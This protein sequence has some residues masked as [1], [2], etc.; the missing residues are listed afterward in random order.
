M[1]WKK[2]RKRSSRVKAF[3]LLGGLSALFSCAGKSSFSYAPDPVESTLGEKSLKLFVATDLHYLAP[4]LT[5]YGTAFNETID[6]SDAK[7]VRYGATILDA[8]LAE[9]EAAKPDALL[10]SGDLT[11]NGEERSHQ[12]L[13]AK[14][15][16]LRE[17]GIAILVIPGNHD[18]ENPYSYAYSD[19][20]VT[21]V[22]SVDEAGFLSLYQDVCFHHVLSFDPDSLSYV[23]PLRKDLWLLSLSGDGDQTKAGR[24]PESTLSWAK[25]ELEKARKQGIKV[26]GMTHESVLPQIP[27]FEE[28]SLMNAFE[29]RDLYE[30]EGVIANLSGHLHLQHYAQGEGFPD[31][32]TSSMLVSP[33]HYAEIA[34][35]PS[36]FAYTTHSIDVASY[37][38]KE[39][40]S[41]P[42]LLAFPA[43]AKDFFRSSNEKRVRGRLEG[44]AYTDSE[45]ELLV[46]SYL[47]LNY[48]FYSGAKTAESLYPEGFALW[49]KSTLPSAT[50]VR[51]MLA[52]DDKDF[53]QYEKAL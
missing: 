28:F 11:Y 24:I 8:F 41:D 49:R 25:E 17:E 42:D 3:L 44:S 9:V 35:T 34:L 4:E 39:G 43:Y 7:C 30:E 14:L 10:L 46:S 52:N 15:L 47:E 21:A 53:N 23:Y 19:A 36:S 40:L 50:Y 1:I 18:I 38:E 31:L 12:E 37:A 45:K 51:T 32:C 6:N 13:A 33:N 48:N 29:I 20:S 16:P 22:P 2:T 27:N 5:D 26:V